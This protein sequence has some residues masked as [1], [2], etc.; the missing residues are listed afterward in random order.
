MSRKKIWSLCTTWWAVGMLVGIAADYY[1][2]R[3][4]LP[5]APFVYQAF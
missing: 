3:V 2:Y 1:L 4:W 5:L